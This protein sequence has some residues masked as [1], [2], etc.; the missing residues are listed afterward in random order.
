MSSPNTSPFGDYFQR[1]QQKDASAILS[2]VIFLIFFV[3]WWVAFGMEASK[4]GSSET[5]GLNYKEYS[6]LAFPT[7]Q[8]RTWDD[9]Y[10]SAVCRHCHWGVIGGNI[11][12]QLC[13][14]ADYLF[15][16][17]E[18]CLAQPFVQSRTTAKTPDGNSQ[19]I[20]F[21]YNGQVISDAT[22]ES[23]IRCD[24]SVRILVE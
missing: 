10:I 18:N 23:V 6:E 11:I 13:Y 22:T 4:V 15:C 16:I 9:N 3:I 17:A 1:L 24:W 7:F 2:A 21:N 19:T 20:V 8:F 14:N 5:F 12:N